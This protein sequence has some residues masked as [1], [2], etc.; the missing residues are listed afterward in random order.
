MKLFGILCLGMFGVA[1][2]FLMLR[3]A[4]KSGL[5]S[6]VQAIFI[7]NIVGSFIIGALFCSSQLKSW[8]SP[9]MVSMI[10][11]GFLGALTTFST[12]SLDVLRMFQTGEWVNGFLYLVL[13]PVSGV[14]AC[15]LGF[16]LIKWVL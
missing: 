10:S 14:F 5:V 2:R 11:V 1:V 3:W 16:Q 4:E 6:S 9:D 15:F 7:I 12:F 13:S 8:L